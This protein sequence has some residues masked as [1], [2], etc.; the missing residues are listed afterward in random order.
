[1]SASPSLSPKNYL[2]LGILANI[3]DILTDSFSSDD[4]APSP[5]HILHYRGIQG[6]DMETLA[7]EIVLDFLQL[8]ALEAKRGILGG[9]CIL[10]VTQAHISMSWESFSR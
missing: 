3:Q 4:L 10:L 6:P 2:I 9:S 5:P 1:M 8:L 7:L